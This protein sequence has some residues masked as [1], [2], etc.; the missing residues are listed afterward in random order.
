MATLH[1]RSIPDTLYEQIKELAATENQSLSAEVVMLL[2]RAVDG[3]QRRANQQHIIET[4]RRRRFVPRT[5]MPDSVMLLRED[6][7]R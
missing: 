6:R 2:R 3:Q 1:V 4:M 7:E 5:G